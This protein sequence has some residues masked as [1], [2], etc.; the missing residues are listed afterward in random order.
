MGYTSFLIY[1]YNFLFGKYKFRLMLK[2]TN[3]GITSGELMSV[4]KKKILIFTTVNTTCVYFCDLTSFQSGKNMRLTSP[5]AD[6]SFYTI[7]VQYLH[8]IDNFILL[9]YLVGV[10]EGS[11]VPSWAVVGW[12][13]LVH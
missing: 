13:V 6:G 10:C 1:I 4:F 12:S 9:V 11:V 5:S 7:N 8:N 3:P 2:Q